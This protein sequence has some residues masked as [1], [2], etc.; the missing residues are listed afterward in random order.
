[1]LIYPANDMHGM[2]RIN[3]LRKTSTKHIQ[4]TRADTH[5]RPSGLKHYNI[6]DQLRKTVFNRGTFF[7]RNSCKNDRMRN[8][9]VFMLQKGQMGTHQTLL[10]GVGIP[11]MDP[12]TL[13]P[14]SNGSKHND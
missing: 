14:A 8:V 6:S 10:S 11:H 2:C 1:M 3:K 7:Y 12:S 5:N 4:H 13:Q 9:Y